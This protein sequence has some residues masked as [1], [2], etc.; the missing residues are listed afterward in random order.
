MAQ[1]D[2]YYYRLAPQMNTGK[3]IIC[4]LMNLMILD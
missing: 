2:E 4:Q 3:G 1:P